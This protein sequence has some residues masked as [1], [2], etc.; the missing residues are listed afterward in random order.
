M[1]RPWRRRRKCASCTD[2]GPTP[3]AETVGTPPNVVFCSGPCPRRGNTGNPA[4]EPARRGGPACLSSWLQG[5]PWCPCRQHGN[6][7]A[8]P[9]QHA[10]MTRKMHDLPGWQACR[11]ASRGPRAPR[12]TGDSRLPLQPTIPSSLVASNVM[13]VC[14][15]NSTRLQL[16]SPAGF[17]PASQ[18]SR[19]SCSDQLSYGDLSFI[20]APASLTS[21]WPRRS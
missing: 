3:S 6:T 15:K 2:S 9:G 18:R 11:V 21:T 12:H 7:A 5:K 14:T 20:T 17:E 19:F 10:S 1:P 4:A 8:A 16:V 13:V